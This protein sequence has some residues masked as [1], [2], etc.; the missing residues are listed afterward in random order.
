MKEERPTLTS[1]KSDWSGDPVSSQGKGTET[2]K[3][4]YETEFPTEVKRRTKPASATKKK[5][6]GPSTKSKGQKRS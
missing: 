5:K 6:T 2:K 3:K 1:G 4:R